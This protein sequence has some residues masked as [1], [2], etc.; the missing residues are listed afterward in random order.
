MD[1]IMLIT[2]YIPN[3]G[4]VLRDKILPQTEILTARM[5]NCTSSY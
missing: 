3:K 1:T 4:K 2:A 5:L